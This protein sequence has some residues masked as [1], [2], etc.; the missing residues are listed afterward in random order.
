VFDAAAC[1]LTLFLLC[2]TAC[3]PR[4]YKPPNNDKTVPPSVSSK[5]A[6]G[7]SLKLTV[8]KAGNLWRLSAALVPHREAVGDE[9]VVSFGLPLPP[10]VLT[11]P[12]RV[13]VMGPGGAEVPRYVKTLGDW[14]RVPPARLLCAGLPPP[15]Q[16]GVRSAL[17]QLSHSFTDTNPVI[18]TIEVGG[19]AAKRVRDKP[20][21]VR[22]TWRLVKEG[23]FS[24]KHKVH[25]PKVYVL[26]PPRWLACSNLTTL[27]SIAGEHGFLNASDAGQVNYFYTTFNDPRANPKGIRAKDRID[28]LGENEPWLY[29]RAQTY[30]NGYF[31]TG[32]LDFLREAHRA[33]QYYISLLY[34]S[35]DC[36]GLTGAYGCSGHFRLLSKDPRKPYKDSKYSYNES[37]ATLYWLT[38]DP[39]PLKH[40]ADVTQATKRNVPLTFEIN[41]MKVWFTE[42][43]WANALLAPL[44]EYEVSGDKALAEY[45]TKGVDALF[46]SQ[47]NPFPPGSKNPVNGCWNHNWEQTGKV[48][49]CPWKMSLLAHALLRVYHTLG[50]KRIPR[51][52][53][54]AARCVVDRALYF[55]KE[56][57]R[58]TPRNEATSHGAQKSLDG[59]PWSDAEHAID[60]AY[61]TALGAYF[62]KDSAQRKRWT[63]L[64]RKL[65]KTHEK[66]LS[67]WDYNTKH[68]WPGN[69]RPRFRLSPPRKYN[70]WYKNAGAIGWL[71]GA[72]TAV[73]R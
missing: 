42:R 66:M 12:A 70:W 5:Y 38:G 43:H 72:P 19:H 15:R 51:V 23:S 4:P 45:V 17:V 53:V 39:R 3:K 71:I 60:I 67:N 56:T 6:A 7:G 64:T 41:N 14:R 48:G 20:V 73:H 16:P 59:D 55:P 9:V 35:A 69:K 25:E 21:P 24:E 2:G 27:S 28:Y 32:S 61:V 37:L 50:D 8:T 22:S 49:I 58:W 30:Y 54:D 47:Q 65:I 33:A 1:G 10:G 62:T 68:G 29:D 52:L 44:F 11:D 31:R 46:R 13:R 34:T 57:K 63:D 40:L 36:E 26:L 18:L